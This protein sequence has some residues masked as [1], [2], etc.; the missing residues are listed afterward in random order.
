MS[1][2]NSSTL[3]TLLGDYPNTKALKSGELRSANVS[4]EFADVKVP[5]TAFKDVVRHLKYDVAELAIVTF[6]QAKA[7]GKPLVLLPAVVVGALPHPLLVYNAEHRRILPADL[8]GKRVGIRA[9]SVTTAAWVRG[10]LQNDYGVDLDEIEWVT[11]E[12]AHVAEYSDPP[13]A[14][15]APAGKSIVQMLSDHEIDAGVV[16]GPDLKDTR[17][18]PVI[19]NPHDAAQHWCNK[20]KALPINHMLVVKESLANTNPFALQEI[21]RL[22]RES[23][24]A[25]PRAETALDTIQFGLANIRRSLE[26]IISYSTQQGLIPEQISVDDLF[27]EVT[28]NLI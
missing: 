21:F 11:F 9:Y 25:M 19:E 14:V 18:Q 12:D 15:R 16:G 20:H 26:L 4:F 22:L 24:L 5:N 2:S 28:G 8:K 23:K 13:T 6:L 3:K 10:V 27:D 1:T 7:H 17:F